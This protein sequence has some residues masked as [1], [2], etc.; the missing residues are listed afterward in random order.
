MSK[1]MK[2]SHSKD[3]G[4]IV[5]PFAIGWEDRDPFYIKHT[6]RLTIHFLW[7]HWAWWFERGGTES[8]PR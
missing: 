7:W 6:S 8:K 5:L 1:Y 2:R 4:Y 3:K